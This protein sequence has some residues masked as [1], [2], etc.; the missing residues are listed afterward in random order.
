MYY[1]L[2]HV[3]DRILD[4]FLVSL[5]KFQNYVLFYREPEPAPG[6]KFPEPE[7]SQNRPA[8]KPCCHQFI[9]PTFWAG[10]SLH[11]LLVPADQDLCHAH[12]P[13]AQ[14]EQP[15]HEPVFNIK[16]NLRHLEEC[17]DDLRKLF[18]FRGF[19]CRLLIIL[20]SKE[21]VPK[22]LKQVSVVG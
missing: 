16:K 11:D 15:D 2:V 21:R 13:E 4:N 20:V 17:R 12:R 8:P 1:V 7:P 9:N 22:Q 3:L 18:E 10:R 19:C 5:T 6:W 14:Q